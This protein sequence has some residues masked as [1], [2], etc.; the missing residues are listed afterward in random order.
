MFE[1]LSNIIDELGINLSRFMNDGK[2][3]IIRDFNDLVDI[4]NEYDTQSLFKKIS[5]SNSIFYKKANNII[6]D[7][8]LNIEVYNFYTESLY[9]PFEPFSRTY[10]SFKNL[11]EIK[12]LYISNNKMFKNKKCMIFLHSYGD[13]NFELYKYTLIPKFVKE[14]NIDIYLMELPHHINRQIPGSPFS[15]ALFFSGN[16]IMTIEAF[17]QAVSDV[18]QISNQI[19]KKYDEIYIAGINLGGHITMFTTLIED[20]FDKYIMIQTGADLNYYIDK[21]KISKF[22]EKKSK[23][24]GII[25]EKDFNKF[26]KP[27]NFHRYYPVVEGEK[28]VIVAGKYDK[29]IPFW[30]V[31]NLEKIFV[32]P[33]TI[34]YD[35]GNFSLGLIYEAIIQEIFSHLPKRRN[36]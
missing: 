4:I 16:P 14:Y 17:R 11:D 30:S 26:Y 12:G 8:F 25:T 28:I 2:Y 21:I 9:K 18:S 34:Y 7:E 27:L 29:I 35:G 23:E 10:D 33:K 5:Q 3:N 24:Y 1:F 32:N 6:A 13:R 36:Y 31:K 22:F 15:G 19:R 20:F